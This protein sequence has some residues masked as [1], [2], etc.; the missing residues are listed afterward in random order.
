VVKE[1]EYW[2]PKEGHLRSQFPLV[3]YSLARLTAP[4]SR[5]P[6]A[7]E[8]A[9]KRRQDG[10]REFWAKSMSKTCQGYGREYII[11]L[12]LCIAST[13][14]YLQSRGTGNNVDE[15]VCDLGLSTSI[16]G[17]AQSVH[18]ITCILGSIVHG[19]LL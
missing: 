7:G 19:I 13:I 17:H 8:G 11:V 1:L 4:A 5:D 6:L 12:S 9:G 16:V 2:Y 3:N 18:H 15:I 10:E 14:L